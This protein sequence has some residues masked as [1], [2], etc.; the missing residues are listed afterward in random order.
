VSPDLS[1]EWSKQAE[2]GTPFMLHLIRWIALRLGR[3]PAR[4]ILYPITLYFLLFAPVARSASYDFLR[5]AT[6]RRAHWWQVARHIHHFSATI[7]DRVFLLTDKHSEL[8]IRTHNLEA[9]RQQ[10]EGTAGCLLL[11]SHI[12]SF[13]ALRAL[14]VCRHRIPVKILMQKEHNAMI[15]RI[16]H[17]LNPDIDNTVIQAGKVDVMLQVQEFLQR[18]YVIG[19]L[20]D[21]VIGR[22]KT[23]RCEVLGSEVD[24]PTGPLIAAAVLKVPV[25]LFFCIYQGGNRYDIFFEDFADRITVERSQ[26][27]HDLHIWV[28]KYADRLTYRARQHPYNWF[29]FYDYWNQHS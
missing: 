9:L 13:E 11:G 23:T 3:F 17:S 6:G 7:L 1:Q 18:G 21:R 4:L 28:Q 19:M 22:R 20:A 8:D 10:L 24:L 16:L 14:G 5:R 12:G 15:T 2:R 27:D 29:N 26:R 25:M